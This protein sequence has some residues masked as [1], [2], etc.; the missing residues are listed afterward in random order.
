MIKKGSEWFATLSELEQ[1]Q[2]KANCSQFEFM[3]KAECVFSLFIS[4][5]FQFSKTPE[6]SEGQDYWNKIAERKH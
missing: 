1:K 3:M 5:A 6:D 4:G 2:Y